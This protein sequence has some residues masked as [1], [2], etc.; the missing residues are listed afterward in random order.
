MS[1]PD[2]RP[3]QELTRA[4][5]D[6]EAEQAGEGHVSTVEVDDVPSVVW[7]V[8]EDTGDHDPDDD[9]TE[10]VDVDDQGAGGLG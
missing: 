2:E 6:V 4:E 1:E 10:G 8:W 3:W 9:H 5:Q 7:G